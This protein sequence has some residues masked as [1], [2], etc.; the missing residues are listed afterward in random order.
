MGR[1]GKESHIH[2]HHQDN[3]WGSLMLPGLLRGKK[4]VSQKCP[5]D[6]GRLAL[7]FTSSIPCWLM[8]APPALYSALLSRIVEQVLAGSG[9]I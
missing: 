3:C 6:G 5:T 7:L 9:N 1:S 2:V 4:E 8:V